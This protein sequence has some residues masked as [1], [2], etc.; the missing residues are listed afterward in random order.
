MPSADVLRLVDLID[1]VEQGDFDTRVA[2]PQ[3]FTEALVAQL[4]DAKYLQF[5]KRVRFLFCTF[6]VDCSFGCLQAL[7]EPHWSFKRLVPSFSKRSAVTKKSVL[8]LLASIRPPTETHSAVAGNLLMELF[9]IVK[10]YNKIVDV[11]LSNDDATTLLAS[12][13]AKSKSELDDKS[14]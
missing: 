7:L 5:A 2:L 10:K 11:Q 6:Q 8:K 9:R 3:R 14:K 12:V 4:D 1:Q 13:K